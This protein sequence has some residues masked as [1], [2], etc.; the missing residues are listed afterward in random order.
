V[1]KISLDQLSTPFASDRLPIVLKSALGEGS[2]FL[3]D[4]EDGL[5]LRIWNWRVKDGLELTLNSNKMEA[6]CHL[7][8]FLHAPDLY[9]MTGCNVKRNSIWDTVFFSSSSNGKMVIPAS[10]TIQCISMSFS[11]EWLNK[12]LAKGDQDLRSLLGKLATNSPI[13]MLENMNLEEKKKL[14]NFRRWLLMVGLHR[15]ISNLL[16]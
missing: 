16:S 8:F 7:V 5:K 15:F 14:L 2:L 1:H 12:N 10:A 13:C 6:H 4:L 11:N 9:L 3:F